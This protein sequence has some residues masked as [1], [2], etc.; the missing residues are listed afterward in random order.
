MPSTYMNCT[1]RVIY[2]SLKK[3]KPAV[4]FRTRIP[5]LRHNASQRE[6]NCRLWKKFYNG[7]NTA[8]EKEGTHLFVGSLDGHVSSRQTRDASVKERRDNSREKYTSNPGVSDKTSAVLESHC[9]IIFVFRRSRRNLSE[10]SVREM[11][12]HVT[13]R[14]CY[15]SNAWKL[16]A[17]RPYFLNN[18]KIII[19]RST[20]VVE[21][22]RNFPSSVADLIARYRDSS[23]ITRHA[24]FTPGSSRTPDP[25]WL[26][27]N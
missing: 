20:L 4:T 18:K 19:I 16:R 11:E 17:A 8:H 7:G 21:S 26:C 23:H 5:R 3:K 10:F 24:L 27:E 22:R 9:R 25:S 13:H 6:R 15:A 12:R 14:L 1:T 2:M